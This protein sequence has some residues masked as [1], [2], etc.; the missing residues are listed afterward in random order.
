[1]KHLPDLFRILELTRSQPQY[2]YVPSDVKFNELSNLAEHHYLVTMIAWQISLYVNNNGGEID[3][4]KVLEYCLVH[5]LGELFGGD[6]GR[7]YVEV[8]KRA[9]AKAKEFEAE[10][11]KFLAKFFGDERKRFNQL[12]K[13]IMTPKNDEAWIFK[14]ADYMECAHF[15]KYMGYFSRQDE[16]ILQDSVPKMVKK[17]KNIETKKLLAE[18]VT[19]WLKEIKLEKRAL[20]VLKQGKK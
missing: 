19:L 1:M 2:G 16:Q 8:N 14:M 15:L 18:F 9:R 20:E 3:I 12:S 17:I 6:I 7:T 5:D 4:R 10:N 11:Q 13:D